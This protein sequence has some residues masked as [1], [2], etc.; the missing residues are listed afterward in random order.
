MFY[1]KIYD[2]FQQLERAIHEYINFYNYTRIKTK[3]KGLS[4]TQYRKQPLNSILN[5]T[6]TFGVQYIPRSA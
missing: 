2:N 5:Q 3:Y 6:A 1:G 4:P